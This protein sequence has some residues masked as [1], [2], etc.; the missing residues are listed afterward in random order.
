[1]LFAGVVISAVAMFLG[2]VGGGLANNLVVQSFFLPAPPPKTILFD[3][4]TA[5]AENRIFYLRN[6]VATRNGTYWP[7]PRPL[8]NIPS[9]T[10]SSNAPADNAIFA[11]PFAFFE[12]SLP[13]EL[14]QFWPLAQLSW[15]SWR[16][17][18]HGC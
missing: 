15:C 8:H 13:V 2:T 17:A 7:M 12:F 5:I 14:T 11:S 10:G 9:A 6:S 4:E 16:Y 1:M 18:Y 3:L